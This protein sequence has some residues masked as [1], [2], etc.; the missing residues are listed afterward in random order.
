M[1]LI[2]GGFSWNRADIKN[3]HNEM[4]TMEL[5]MERIKD[6]I[7]E[8]TSAIDKIVLNQQNIYTSLV[9]TTDNLHKLSKQ[10]TCNEMLNTVFY[11]DLN[12]CMYITVQSFIRGVNSALLG[13]LSLDL[14][15]GHTLKTII[16]HN[17]EV[18]ETINVRDFR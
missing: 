18:R 5:N 1:S 15:S 6:K 16:K 17:V 12:N 9:D 13:D 3:L 11:R 2:V 14:I 7:N 4:I 8:Q 10:V